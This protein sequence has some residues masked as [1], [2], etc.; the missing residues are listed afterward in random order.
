MISRFYSNVPLFLVGSVRCGLAGLLVLV[1]VSGVS[2]REAQPN[3]PRYVIYYNSDAS[4]A[5]RLLGTPYTHVIL[6][7]ITLAADANADAPVA[8]VVP[9]K[10]G[11]ALQVVPQLQAE[12]KQVLIS[13]G[14]G[15]M[16]GDAYTSALG[17]IDSLAAQV[18]AF[19]V[20]HG[21]D[22]V[23]IDFE[24]SAALEADRPAGM[25]DGVRFLIDFTRA[26]RTHLPAGALLT[27]VPQAPYLD[28]GW[29]GGPYL[30]VLRESGR[31]IDWITVQYYNNPDFDAPVG[32]RI[33]GAEAHPVAWS[34]T[35]I[36]SGLGDLRWPPQRTL[37][38]LPVYRDDAANGH[39]APGEVVSEVVCPLRSRFSKSFGGL[40][41]WQFSTLTSDHRYWN[42][43]LAPFVLEA[44]CGGGVDTK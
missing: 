44:A 31:M 3:T 28:P 35:G 40:T 9:E 37:V 18:S 2:A 42:T 8:L 10:L 12:G 30:D 33:V 29:H 36:T 16:S 38:G 34:F 24:V 6:S 21:L 25:F 22:G 27:H 23:D 4:P 26:L 43:Q 32:A 17:R 19:V 14:G 39:L 15:D 11:P 5:T 7:F 13:F 1:L 20:R 41:G